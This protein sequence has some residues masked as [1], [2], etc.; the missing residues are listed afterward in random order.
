TI[1]FGTAPL[2]EIGALQQHLGCI[3]ERGALQLRESPLALR[4]FALGI[5]VL[6]A[7]VVPVVH[8]KGERHYLPRR[9]VL[10]DAGEPAVS[11]RAAAAALGRVALDQPRG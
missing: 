7:D 10:R 3:D 9:I 4:K 8:V 5:G 1:E 2:P 11:R 6:P